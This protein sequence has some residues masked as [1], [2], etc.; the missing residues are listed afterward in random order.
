VFGGGREGGREGARRV[1]WVSWVGSDNDG[2]RDGS[3]TT[4]AAGEKA[5]AAVPSGWGGVNGDDHDDHGRK[6]RRRASGGRNGQ[7]APHCVLGGFSFEI[8]GGGIAAF[9]GAYASEDYGRPSS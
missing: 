4:R 5:A 7:L 6:R 3:A 8:E 9:L 2:S 1:W